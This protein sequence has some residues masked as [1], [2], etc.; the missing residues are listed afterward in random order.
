MLPHN[1]NHL[2]FPF[3]KKNRAHEIRA[4]AEAFLISKMAYLVH[5]NINMFVTVASV[6]SI[7]K[8]QGHMQNVS[9][10]IR[11]RNDIPAVVGLTQVNNQHSGKL[12]I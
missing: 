12:C 6:Y 4:E 3:G 5:R 1:R 10:R 7:A 11:L 2:L 9:I 8:V